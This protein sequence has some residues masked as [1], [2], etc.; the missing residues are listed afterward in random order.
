MPIKCRAISRKSNISSDELTDYARSADAKISRA[1]KGTPELEQHC[2]HQV[3][4][5]FKLN[6][7]LGKAEEQFKR[8]IKRSSSAVNEA[9]NCSSADRV[10]R[11]R[12]VI[13]CGAMYKRSVRV[14][15]RSQVDIQIDLLV[16]SSQNSAHVISEEMPAMHLLA[17]D[18]KYNGVRRPFNV[19]YFVSNGKISMPGYKTE[20]KRMNEEQG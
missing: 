19:Y 5:D 18:A 11:T 14:L 1:G 4:E 6:Q 12:T 9:Q 8:R 3:V 13:E 10:Q 20:H 16:L 17:K 2:L 15:I 7:Q